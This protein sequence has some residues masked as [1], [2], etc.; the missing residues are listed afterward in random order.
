MKFSYFNNGNK[1]L[2]LPAIGRGF[3]GTMSMLAPKFSAFLGRN[4]LMKPYAKRH[5]E[6]EL[7]TPESELNLQTSIG[8]VHVNLFGT[9]Q[10]VILLSHGWG[11]SSHTFQ[12]MILSLTEQGYR[13]AAIDHIG[14]GK[15]SGNQSH[16]LSFV[17]TLEILIEHFN[18]E[19]MSVYGIV[20]HSMGA[21]A[22]LNLPLYALENK[23]IILISSPVNFFELMFEKVEQVGI[24][25]KLLTKVLESI[26]HKYGKTWHQLTTESNR[27]KLALD[28]TFIHDSQDR[29]APIADVISFLE[30]EKTPLIT[31]E[32]L[33]HKKILGDTKVI[34]N[35]TQVLSF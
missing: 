4:I 33:G 8:I 35:I 24:S 16:L 5:Y 32:G 7:I 29:F 12:Q 2:G 30:Q 1:G 25:R 9:G 27:E 6:F 34:E 31:T 22:T 21:I 23:K 28:I 26:S 3:T 11:D 20:A 13:V 10:K 18:E 14:H 17:E 19:K 15:S